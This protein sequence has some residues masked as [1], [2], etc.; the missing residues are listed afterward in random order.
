MRL[1]QR[2]NTNAKPW[3]FW[4]PKY[5]YGF[6]FHIDLIQDSATILI[7]EDTNV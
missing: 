2:N 6:T 7:M 1:W 3:E 4:M 5:N